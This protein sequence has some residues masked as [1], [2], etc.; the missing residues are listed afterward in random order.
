[1]T[2]NVNKY[3]TQG[4][5]EVYNIIG[6]QGIKYYYVPY[7]EHKYKDSKDFINYDFNNKIKIPATINSSL[8]SDVD[9]ESAQTYLKHTQKT[10]TIQFT[11]N[12][13]YPLIPRELD[14]I[15]IEYDNGTVENYLIV[16]VDNGVLL[17]SI[18]ISVRCLAMKGTLTKFQW[19]DNGEEPHE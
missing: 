15:Y 11:L 7:I 8:A 9:L 4:I 2:A 12:S 18:Y 14:R 10:A 17:Q 5:E 3:I 13:I 6:G 19:V 16:G 1:M